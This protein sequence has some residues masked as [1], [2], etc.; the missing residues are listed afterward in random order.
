MHLDAR[1]RGEQRKSLAPGPGFQF[2]E[3][4]LLG[5]FGL[6]RRGGAGRCGEHAKH[7]A[8]QALANGED[9]LGAATFRAAVEGGA[10]VAG[11]PTHVVR[12]PGKAASAACAGSDRCHVG[13]RVTDGGDGRDRELC[14]P[15]NGGARFPSGEQAHGRCGVTIRCQ[16]KCDAGTHCADA[17]LRVPE[18]VDVG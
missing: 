1:C 7:H 11:E 14:E 6:G 5:G 3:C 2:V 18:G 9:V 12:E 8:T 15:T 16:P 17:E 10:P 4:A 13:G